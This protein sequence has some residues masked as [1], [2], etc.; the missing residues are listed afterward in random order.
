[1]I[2]FMLV[3]QIGHPILRDQETFSYIYYYYYFIYY[4]SLKCAA[5]FLSW[6]TLRGVRPAHDSMT[7][8]TDG[9]GHF[10]FHRCLPHTDIRQIYLRFG[11]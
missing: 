1:M 2:L 8:L 4:Y 11:W 3:R 10:M 6:L 7:V 9:T 5:F